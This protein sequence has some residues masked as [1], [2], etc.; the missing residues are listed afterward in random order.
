M[1][2]QGFYEEPQQQEQFM[3]TPVT[4]D[5]LRAQL[6]KYAHRAA[7]P[8]LEPGAR[9]TSANKEIVQPSNFQK[10]YEMLGSI[11]QAG[12]EMLGA[13]QARSAYSRLQQIQNLA[14]PPSY[15][16]PQLRNNSYGRA[17]SAIGN[18]PSNPRENFKFAQQLA[19]QFGWDSAGEL[20]AWYTL[21][22][23]ESGWRNN[24]QNPNS[25]AFGIGQFLNSTW[26]GVGIPKTSDPYMQVMAMA[27]YIKNRYGSPSNALRF[28]L[29]HNWY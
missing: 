1:S 17:G 8:I 14:G 12:N 23:K 27:R 16:S 2:Q 25:T 22:M 26:A 3:Q 15:Q 4:G 11:N 7:P 20:G 5:Y 10:F 24:A 29:S 9:V 18:V 21:G 28:H 6:E 19:S 13:A